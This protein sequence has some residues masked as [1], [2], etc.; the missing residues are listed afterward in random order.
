[1]DHRDYCDESAEVIPF[2]PPVSEC[3]DLQPGLFES[4]WQCLIAATLGVGVL[5]TLILAI[6]GGLTL[7]GLR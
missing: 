5:S 3:D 2:A 4:W 1:M 6:Y 7:L